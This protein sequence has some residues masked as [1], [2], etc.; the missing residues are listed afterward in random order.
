MEGGSEP[1]EREAKPEDPGGKGQRRGMDAGDRTV[2]QVVDAEWWHP[3]PPVQ[4]TL[5]H[6]P[7][8]LLRT[9]VP[10]VSY[11]SDSL[12]LSVAPTPIQALLLHPCTGAPH[13][14]SAYCS[15]DPSPSPPPPHPAPHTAP[16]LCPTAPP[17]YLHSFPHLVHPSM[18]RHHQ[19]GTDTDIAGCLRR[20]N[21]VSGSASWQCQPP[22]PQLDTGC[23]R[24]Q[25]LGLHVSELGVTRYGAAAHCAA[26][27]IQNERR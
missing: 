27:G 4:F 20:S 1:R 24:R 11:Q 22:A 5:H 8:H 9:T 17:P 15:V 2:G 25:S 21:G 23:G 13:L 18:A 7:Q 16:P 19:R 6:T 14:D 26:S 10:T 3:H 12:A